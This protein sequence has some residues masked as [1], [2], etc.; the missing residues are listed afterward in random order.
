MNWALKNVNLRHI[1]AKKE[2]LASD[3][4]RKGYSSIIIGD[5][6]FRIERRLPVGHGSTRSRDVR[7]ARYIHGFTLGVRTGDPPSSSVV[8]FRGAAVENVEAILVCSNTKV[9]EQHQSRKELDGSSA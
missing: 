4:C 7:W 1:D 3:V 9:S 6:C 5:D 2:N 8:L